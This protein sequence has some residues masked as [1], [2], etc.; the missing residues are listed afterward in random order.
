MRIDSGSSSPAVVWD[1]DGTLIDSAGDIAAAMDRALAAFGLPPLGEARVRTFVG[2]GARALVQ[3]CVEAVGGAFTEALHD[4]FLGEYRA[5]LVERTHVHPAALRELLPR[6]VAPMAVV[7]NKPILHTRE[8]LDT[9][10][11]GP[12]F[13]AVLGGDSLPRRK[14]DPAPIQE[15]MRLLGVTGAVMVGDGPQDVVAGQSAGLPVI[16]VAWGIHAP[17]G[18]DVLVQDVLELEIALHRAGVAFR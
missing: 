10:G 2:D 11:L 5:H 18:A 6:I 17:S 16:G 9:L 14:P 8:I 7:T 3:R 13:G 4:R 12:H 1:L 15:A